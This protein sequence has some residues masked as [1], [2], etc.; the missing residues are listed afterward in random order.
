VSANGDICLD[1]LKSE[2]APAL[3]VSK[4]RPCYPC[5]SIVLRPM[6]AELQYA[7]LGQLVCIISGY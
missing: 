2:W 5:T 1:I 4:V 7:A 3:T 6:Y